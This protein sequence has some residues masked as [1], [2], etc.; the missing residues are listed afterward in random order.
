VN[1]ELP[2]AE[3]EHSRLDDSFAAVDGELDA[4]FLAEVGAV[5]RQL[6]AERASA[7]DAAVQA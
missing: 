7:D 6:S 5:L 2:F 1:L 3:P 4:L